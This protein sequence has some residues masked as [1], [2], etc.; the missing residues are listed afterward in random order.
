MSIIRTI[1]NEYARENLNPLNSL[2]RIRRLW[3]DR[4]KSPVFAGRFNVK[5]PAP[6]SGGTF[7]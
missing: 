2:D 5:L 3:K 7:R 1:W 6:K 4:L